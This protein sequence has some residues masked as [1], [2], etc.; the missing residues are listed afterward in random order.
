MAAECQS[1][2]FFQNICIQLDNMGGKELLNRSQMATSGSSTKSQSL[3]L[4]TLPIFSRL[5]ISVRSA[6]TSS[7]IKGCY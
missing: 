3:D 1:C 6:E 4:K 7:L 2:I 5:K